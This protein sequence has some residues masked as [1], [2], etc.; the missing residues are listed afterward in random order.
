MFLASVASIPILDPSNVDQNQLTDSKLPDYPKTTFNSTESS[1]VNITEKLERTLTNI[2]PFLRD[3][4]TEFAHIL[5]KTLVGSHGQELLPNGLHALKQTASVVELVM[6]LCSQ[7]WQNS[8]Q[9]HAGLAFIEL[10]NEGRL[11]SHASKDHVVKVA[12]EA[13]FILNRMRADDI[14][15]SEE[16]EQLCLQT[17]NERK[18]EEELSDHFITSSHQRYEH[19]AERLQEKFLGQMINDESDYLN[20]SCPFWKLDVWEDDLRRRRRLIADYH[21][22]SH[23]DELENLTFQETNDEIQFDYKQFKQQK[24]NSFL[25][26]EN[27]DLSQV[28][29]KD[30]EQELTGPIRYSTDCSLISG[31]RSIQGTLA[32]THDALIF[33][34]SENE[35]IDPKIAP[36]IDNL[37]GKWRFSDIRA[38]FSRRY[39]LQDRA[40][41]VFVSN[42]TSIMFAFAD[43]SIMKK[44]VNALPKVG[45]GG[46]YGLPQ[47]RRTSLASPKQL[48]RSAN[49]TQRWQ[50]REIS[51]FEYLM[52]L[53]TIAGRTYQDLNQY[54]IFPWIIADYESEKLDLNAPA[55][56][57][58]LS[59]PIGALNP[60]RKSFFVERYNSS[61]S[62]T[63]TPSF[64]YNTH[65]S[66]AAFTLNWLVRLEPF[67]TYYCHFLDEKLEVSNRTF[68]S[69]G[70][71][72]QN[73][74]RDSSD[75]KE[76]IPELFSLPEMLTNINEYTFGQ[77]EIDDVILPKWAQTPEDF[78]RLN[79]A[80]LE[81]E[82]VSAHLHQWIDL[83]FGYKQRGPEAVRAVNVF[84][85]LTYEGMINFDAI[86]NP[87][88]RKLLEKQMINLGQ[89]P[90]Q[91]LTEPHPPRS[92]L[93]PTTPTA[94]N[95]TPEDVS[96]IMKFSSNAPIIHVSANTNPVL[97]ASAVLTIS[98]K[99]DFSVNKYNP[100][101]TPQPP[102]FSESNQTITTNQQSQ[103]PLSMDSLL[104]LNTGLHRRHLGENFDERIQQRYQSFVVTIDN[105]FIIST[106]YWDKSFRV[107]N[108]D[109]AKTTQ[110]LYGH[111]DIVTC[112]CRSEATASG[113]CFIATGS[114]DSSV[115]IWIW[116]G[117]KGAIV[118]KDSPNQ[119]INPSPAAIL[120]GH[121]SE[122]SCLWIS[123]ELGL[124]LSGS[125]HGYVVQHTLTGEIL[126]AFE[127]PSDMATPRL[128]SS[129][130]DGDVITCYERSKLCLYTLNGKL[131]RQA[132][133]EEETIQVKIF[134]N[135]KINSRLIILI[136]IISI[137]FGHE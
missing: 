46:R 85:Y 79:R 51:N 89:V 52:Y 59:K 37:H 30:L 4:F 107:Q 76:L 56:Y 63:T 49:M 98:N 88:D 100:N 35:I 55:T 131:L 44:I 69:I 126:R 21:G 14:R 7:E 117:T 16:F 60:T 22:N 133:F 135:E 105:R 43:R 50:R 111:F 47:Q 128:L 9:K 91:L 115:C 109:M 96:M 120:T 113:N 77:S 72:W 136:T 41:E 122:I 82:F 86:T 80:A 71:A 42:R 83:I 66:T 29:E 78:I 11:L 25:P 33:D 67:T 125:N 84:Y 58:D 24:T 27:E 36:Y 119:D 15:K 31:I 116:N 106:G 68:D 40:L 123:A 3:I 103:L 114:R 18:Q 132:I 12:N 92:S 19:L 102:H 129:S 90:A 8:L 110:V 13:D 2:A 1:T 130:N 48:F 5:T 104:V 93:V 57:R 75:V 23:D 70:L 62:D 10:V 61:D 17:T 87:N 112:V 108:T 54:P 101:A 20:S 74:Q 45:V 134:E 94:F 118:D 32:I 137:E 6:L 53:N 28:D 73:C 97:S 124:V 99:H 26:D 95:V 81:S 64:H 39:F 65:Y 34:A 127:N 121:R 38:I